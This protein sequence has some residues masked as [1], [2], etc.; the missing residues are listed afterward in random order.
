ARI[1]L[2]GQSAGAVHVASYVSHPELHKVNGGGVA[3]AIMVSGIYDLT[4]LPLGDPEIAYFGSDPS[5]YA[6][7]SSLKG[8][9]ESKTPLM[10]TAAELDP[11]RFIEQYD[12][13]KQATCKSARSCARTYMLPQHNHMSEVYA[14]NT[15]D[16]RL[17][18][19][20]LEFVKAG[21]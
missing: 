6:E 2:M 15:A 14:I 3:G 13:M 4:S 11:L 12:M 10:F 8:L 18:D 7:R 17:T 9:V 16:T 19:Q 1:Y 20:V 21:K 5:R